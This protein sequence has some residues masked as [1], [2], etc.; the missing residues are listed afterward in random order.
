[1]AELARAVGSMLAAFG[2]SQ[3][4]LAERIAPYTQAV[5]EEGVC[6]RC[7]A[8]AARSLLR[9][10]KRRP[11]PAE[12]LEEAR[13][14]MGTGLHAQHVERRTEIGPG[15]PEGWWRTT[16]PEIVRQAWPELDAVQVSLVCRELQRQASLG[17][18]RAEVHGPHGVLASLGG[19]G[20]TERRWWERYLSLARR[21]GRE[22]GAA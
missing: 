19:P 14:L 2:A 20:D 13:E 10:A 17:L 1:M 16:A 9:R 7:A 6:E 21:A 22:E 3:T 18:V 5:A 15:Q 8:A 4:G 11:V 12:L